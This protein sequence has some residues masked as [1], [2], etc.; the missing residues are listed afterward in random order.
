MVID[1]ALVVAGRW[2]AGRG[3]PRRVLRVDGQSVVFRV[4]GQLSAQQRRM[5]LNDFAA[6]ADNVLIPGQ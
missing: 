1:E 4:R 3:S 2:Y 6:W 5:R